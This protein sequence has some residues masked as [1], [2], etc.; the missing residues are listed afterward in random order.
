MEIIF[1]MRNK[2][3]IIN[4]IKKFFCFYLTLFCVKLQTNNIQ[5][6]KVT[7]GFREIFGNK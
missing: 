4:I 6:E 5:L 7:Y 2:K 3:W 1:K